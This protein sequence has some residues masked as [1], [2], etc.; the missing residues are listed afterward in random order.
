MKTTLSILAVIVV[1]LAAAGPAFADVH[2]GKG[3]VV[4]E[5]RVLG[6]DVEIDG[7]ARGPVF[8]VGGNVFV[9]PTGDAANITVIGGRLRTAPGARLHGD[10]FQLGGPTH[11]LNGWS[12][13]AAVLAALALR[14]LLVW[15]VVNAGMRLAAGRHVQPFTAALRDRPGRTVGAGVLASA[16]LLALSLLLLLTV[17]GIPI[18]LMIWG[19]LIIAVPVGVAT[20][21][22]DLLADLSTRR[23]VFLVAA[24]PILGDALLA[25]TMAVGSG[26]LLGL[27]SRAKPGID[28]APL[29]RY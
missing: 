12:L 22:N 2:V 9:G 5:L 25:L 1:L 21:S 24:I 4:N 27:V 19:L 17:V 15:I 14:T 16:A 7:T 10:V 20:L 23:T 13:V 6:Q 18:A 29:A 28:A 3:Q 11:E 26:V 8:V